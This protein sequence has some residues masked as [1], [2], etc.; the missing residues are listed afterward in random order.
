MCPYYVHE[1][2]T[3]GHACVLRRPDGLTTKDL[4]RY[5]GRM[6]SSFPG[7]LWCRLNADPSRSGP[8]NCLNPPL[9]CHTI[10]RITAPA[11]VGTQ[12]KSRSGLA[13]SRTRYTEG[14]LDVQPA[15][16][17][18]APPPPLGKDS[19]DG[20]LGVFVEWQGS[21]TTKF[22]I[23]SPNAHEEPII[24]ATGVSATPSDNC[25]PWR[26]ASRSPCVRVAVW[27]GSRKRRQ[28]Q[29]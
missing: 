3:R 6:R 2:L 5:P 20:H 7:R 15:R 28:A 11:H 10:R 1:K 24:R 21:M 14:G 26:R 18:P 23:E 25:Q 13:D 8:P 19:L 17:S 16:G 29:R 9:L 4:R 27:W 22:L 12:I